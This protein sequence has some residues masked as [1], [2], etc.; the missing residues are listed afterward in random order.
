MMR[1][2]ADGLLDDLWNFPAAFGRSPAEALEA[3]REKLAGLMR[4]SATAAGARQVGVRHGVV[5]ARHGVPVLTL[6]E[7]MAEFRH[8]ITFRAIQGRVYPVVTA[9]AIRNASLHWFEL[10]QLPQAA[11]S[12]LARKIVRKISGK[13]I[14]PQRRSLPTAH[15][16]S[17]Y[18]PDRPA[19]P[20][21]KWRP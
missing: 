10:E 12:Q 14:A 20:Q 19:N 17:A 4:A 15:C 16:S 5:R 8:G 3:L 18:S 11:I 1:G 7:P 21:P 6:G 13:E 9:R 2:L